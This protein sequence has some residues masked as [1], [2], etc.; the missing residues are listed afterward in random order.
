MFY[1][2]KFSNITEKER[3]KLYDELWTEPVA[4][5]ALKYEVSDATLRKHCKKL[6]IPLPDKG[7]WAKLKSGQKV[8]KT[9]LP[10]V[11]REVSKYVSEYLIKFR[12]DLDE[13]T[14]DELLSG[15][16]L[17][18]L[19]ADTISYIKER[20]NKITVP[21]QL[22]DACNEILNH[23]EEI[24]KRK[25]RDR[26][27]RSAVKGTIYYNNIYSKFG[28]NE[29]VFPINVSQT[30]I[31]RAYRIVDA[32]I[33]VLP[34]F[35]ARI[36]VGDNSRIW[37]N[38]PQ[39]RAVITFVK[40]QFS[41]SINEN[42]NNLVLNADKDLKYSDQPDN[43]LEN[44]FSSIIYN[45]LVEG[46]R[47]YAEWLVKRREEERQWQEQIRIWEEEKRQKRLAELRENRLE[48]IKLLL[49][50]ADDWEKAGRLRK[51]LDAIE[52]KTECISNEKEK[53]IIK[54]WIIV[55][56]KKADWLDPL[57]YIEDE[58]LGASQYV[59]NDILKYKGD[60]DSI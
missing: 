7:Y 52:S 53:D 42:G 49:V 37:P 15:K 33:K 10:K 30:N 17:N 25:K 8:A 20:C 46:N 22:R 58:L 40:M 2:S 48:E 16:E 41:I 9:K 23:K 47:R 34:D 12:E 57:V 1:D 13:L 11:T 35:E 59:I 44:Q 45:L 54:K 6:D 4:K 28:E 60:K 29:S 27:L 38:P 50:S 21:N 39:D 3:E 14:D 55:Q 5:V 19:T 56:R 32:L 26:E 36:F 43:R 18:L 24:E 51:Y 31:N